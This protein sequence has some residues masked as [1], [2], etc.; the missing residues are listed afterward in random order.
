MKN[1]YKILAAIVLAT[2][3]SCKEAHD[4]QR[5]API[6]ETE[7]YLAL[8]NAD[9]LIGRWENNSPEGNLS[10]T[11]KVE[12]DSTFSGES[13]FVVKNDTVFSEKV[14]LFE[15]NG[16][17]IYKVSVP[18]QNDEKPVEFESS[19]FNNKTMIFENPKHDYPNK[20]I[21]NKVSADSLVAKISGLKKGMQA[22]ETF[23]FKKT[24]NTKNK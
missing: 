19:F 1:N 4:A 15:T 7:K 22:E 24:V 23:K 12:N 5:P 8:K 18:G 3:F 6:I 16:K 9:W 14:S 13:Y 21:Y 2:T 11:W 20:I 17:L 10:E